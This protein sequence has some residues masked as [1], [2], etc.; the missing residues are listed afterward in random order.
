MEIKNTKDMTIGAS[1][2]LIYGA[3]GSGKT[4]FLRSAPHIL[5]VDVDRGLLTL[6]GE[7]IKYIQP[8]SY[9]DILELLHPTTFEGLIEKHKI[10][11]MGW[12]GLHDMSR[13]TLLECCRSSQHEFP[14]QRDW[15]CHH[16][17]MAQIVAAALEFPGTVVF[18]SLQDWARDEK[19]GD[20]LGGVKVP[21]K[22]G[23]Y[24]PKMFDYLFHSEVHPDSKGNPQYYLRT[25]PDGDRWPA[26]VRYGDLA[27]LEPM[28]KETA[29]VDLMKKIKGGD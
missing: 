17:R 26:R 21:G 18:T 13:L 28:N 27:V 23:G 12:D 4:N 3:S 10:K 16:Q 29:F 22:I 25:V 2:I 20:M 7:N 14:L 5:I 19:Y 1:K 24:I 9:N 6:K 11:I 8:N 15:M